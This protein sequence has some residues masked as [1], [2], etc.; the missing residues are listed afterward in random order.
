M[1]DTKVSKIEETINDKLIDRSRENALNFVNFLRECNITNERNDF[2]LYRDEEVCSF[3]FFG[4]K[5]WYI[6]WS[7]SDITDGDNTNVCKELIKFARAKRYEC[8]KCEGDGCNKNPG[9]IKK[10]F[11]KEYQNLCNS[12]VL[13][14]CPSGETLEKIKQLVQYR[15]RDIERK[16][17]GTR[18]LSPCIIKI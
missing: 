5:L 11:G 13:F 14:R 18:G 17:D 9:G 1:S 4:K 12:T 15:I 3:M 8:K 2:Q 10:I 6:G 16:V 7:N